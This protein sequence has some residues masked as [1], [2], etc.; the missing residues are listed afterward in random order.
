MGIIEFLPMYTINALGE[1]EIVGLE[2]GMGR[3]K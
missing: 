2:E 3:R 1:R